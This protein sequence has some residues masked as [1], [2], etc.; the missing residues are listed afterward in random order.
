MRILRVRFDSK[1]TLETHLREAVSKAA[2]SLGVVRLAGKLFHC[3]LVL[4]S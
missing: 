4:M 1:L 2:R 3:P